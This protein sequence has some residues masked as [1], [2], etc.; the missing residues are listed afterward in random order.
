MLLRDARVVRELV[1]TIGDITRYFRLGRPN[2]GKH[3]TAGTRLLGSLD[4]GR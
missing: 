1:E 2:F 4:L 3:P